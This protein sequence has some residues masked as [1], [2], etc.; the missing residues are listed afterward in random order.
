MRYLVLLFLVIACNGQKSLKYDSLIAG[1]WCLIKEPGLAQ[2][3]YGGIKVRPNVGIK[4]TSRA[5][6]IYNYGYKIKNDTLQIIRGIN[7]TVNN[8]IIKLTPDSLILKSLLEKHSI[9]RYYRCN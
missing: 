4:L 5:D 8:P 7:D 2:L 3:N 6:T 1:S 9:Q